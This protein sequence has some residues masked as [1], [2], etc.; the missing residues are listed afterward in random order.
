MK[1]NNKSFE[2]VRRL[3]KDGKDAEPTARRVIKDPRFFR[4]TVRAEIAYTTEH[5]GREITEQVYV[6][7]IGVM[8]DR[9][10]RSKPVNG[11]VLK[12]V[13]RNALFFSSKFLDSIPDLHS[14]SLVRLHSFKKSSLED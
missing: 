4:D 10:L 7:G 5:Y 9:V 1:S 13:Y 14:V 11:N 2:G 3:E 12:D 8:P 6:I